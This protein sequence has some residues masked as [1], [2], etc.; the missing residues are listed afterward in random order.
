[1]V[2]GP[3]R[4]APVRLQPPASCVPS[5]GGGGRGGRRSSRR[6]LPAFA[7][8]GVGLVQGVC[9]SLASAHSAARPGGLQ[10]PSLAPATGAAAG[11]RRVPCVL[12]PS[13]ASA[14]TDWLRDVAGGGSAGPCLCLR[15]P[16]PFLPASALP[17]PPHV[18]QGVLVPGVGAASTHPLHGRRLPP[19]GALG[20]A[21]EPTLPQGVAHGPAAAWPC[22]TDRGV[23]WGL[24][25]SG[26]P[27]LSSGEAC[28]PGTRARKLPAL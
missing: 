13:S 12:R 8:P 17:L 16:S 18:T 2:M 9:A 14:H 21:A 1:M 28:V 5:G 22:R 4:P 15:G 11:D 24:R 27:G 7:L 26:E 19:M 10:A 3:E 20:D 23:G 25:G 6:V